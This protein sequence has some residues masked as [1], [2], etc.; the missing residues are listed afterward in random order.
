MKKVLAIILALSLFFVFTACD[1]SDT[2]SIN[3]DKPDSSSTVFVKPEN[4]ASV[5][6][7]TI[8]PQFRLY[9]DI[10]GDVLAVEPVN[11][12][13]K[14]ISKEITAQT[15]NI[16][17]IIDSIISATNA[18]G[19]VKENATVNLEITEIKDLTVN[20][21]TVLNKAKISADDSFKKL[22]V[23]VEVKTSVAENANKT[24]T[25]DSKSTDISSAESN[26]PSADVESVPA[27]THS[28]S[29]ATCLNA[30]VCSCGAEGGPALGHDF[31]DGTCSRCGANDPDYK[32]PIAQK[33][34]I[35]K[36]MFWINDGAKRYYEVSIDIAN[37]LISY[38][39]GG[40]ALDIMGSEDAVQE[41]IAN[42]EAF[43]F[44]GEWWTGA[45]GGSRVN[46]NSVS[47]S[48]NT[49][50]IT[51]EE[52]TVTLTRDGENTMKV[53]SCNS[54]LVCSSGI[55]SGTTFTLK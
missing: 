29:S 18:G 8:N 2:A 20:A 23:T 53:S 48:G 25:D 43:Q 14:S 11:D 36:G 33:S 5:V 9:L 15:G 54:G 50:T 42:G 30:A 31:K 55:K 49:V 1:K 12:D 16:E 22:K 40:T 34:G 28:Y 17:T 46:I 10:A 44:D 39:G 6:L 3:S 4:Y 7:L 32:T 35:W 13:A 19:F 52:G 47:E 37:K 45:F 41:A 24:E 21:E 26:S 51:T 27:H 38:G